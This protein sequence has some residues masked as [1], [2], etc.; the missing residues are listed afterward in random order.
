MKQPGLTVLAALVLALSGAGNLSAYSLYLQPTA[1]LRKSEARIA[2]I[3]RVEGES[4]PG[5]IGEKLVVKDLVRPVFI[6]REDLQRK[7]APGPEKLDRAFG[8]G[9]WIVPLT[10]GLPAEKILNT[11][12]ERL[13]RMPGGR[14]FLE[15]HRLRVD[16]AA[17]LDSMPDE[18]GLFFVLPSRV[19]LLSPGMRMITVD[20]RA[21]QDGREQVLLRQQVPVRIYRIV[22]VAVTTRTLATG[23][24]LT[25]K[26]WRVERREIDYAPERYLT[27]NLNGR[28]VMSDLAIGA[29]LTESTVQIAPAVRRGQRVE[30][31]YQTAGLVIKC[32]SVAG[33]DGKV[34]DVIPVATVF[35]SGKGKTDLQAR[36]V[37]DGRAVL[38]GPGEQR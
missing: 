12:R 21:S 28:R 4:R 10:V 23:E 17:K 6:S 26:D 25:E 20:V 34:G 19:D 1:I 24:R 5:S 33:R 15:K 9:V 36:I 11:L 27:G 22:E 16:P 35:P 29:A 8:R 38:L 37:D 14:E 18:S 32:R 2:D 3:A 30:L 7:L 13:G 31:V